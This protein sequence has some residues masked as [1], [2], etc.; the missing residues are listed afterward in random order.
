MP[1]PGLNERRV[2][3][4]NV[5]PGVLTGDARSRFRLPC[6]RA[7]TSTGRRWRRWDL[8]FEIVDGLVRVSVFGV[9]R[10]YPG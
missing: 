1:S 7:R 5:D 4:L 10:F 9:S 3:I 6:T 8:I 2:W